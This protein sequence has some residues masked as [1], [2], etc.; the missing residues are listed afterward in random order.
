MSSTDA[1]LNT[2][3]AGTNDILWAETLQHIKALEEQRDNLAQ[4]LQEEKYKNDRLTQKLYEGMQ[5]SLDTLTHFCH[6]VKFRVEQ[7]LPENS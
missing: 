5:S 7:K 6:F 3:S 2:Q 4:K 1:S